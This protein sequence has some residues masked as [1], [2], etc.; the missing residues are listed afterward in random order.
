MCELDTLERV[1]AVTALV[2]WRCSVH[3]AV[4]RR[5][6]DLVMRYGWIVYALSLPAAG[7][8]L[9]LLNA[10]RESS[11]WLGSFLFLVWAIFGYVV[12][13]TLHITD[14]RSSVRWEILVPY[15]IL[16]LATCMLYWWPLWPLCRPLWYV[17]TALYVT[18]TVLNVRS[19]RPAVPAK[20]A[21]DAQATAP[22]QQCRAFKALGR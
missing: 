16:Y 21:A 20:G 19:H 10:G 2:F 6:L 7:V 11:L 8:S 12:E 4:R 3:F 18:Q 17:T 14:W 13:F 15:V 9:V 22:S 5:R 1:H